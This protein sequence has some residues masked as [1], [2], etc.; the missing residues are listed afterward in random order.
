MMK[1]F[2]T[3]FS[4]QQTL[5]ILSYHISVCSSIKDKQIFNLIVSNRMILDQDI[6]PHT[7]TK[8]IGVLGSRL[9]T[10]KV[11]RKVGISDRG[12]VTSVPLCGT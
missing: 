10:G 12:L 5:Q 4:V 9:R 6:G 3:H 2:K 11:G 7:K 1:I 8:N